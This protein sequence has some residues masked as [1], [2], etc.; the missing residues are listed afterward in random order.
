MRVWSKM[1]Y[2]KAE[3]NVMRDGAHKGAITPQEYLLEK[4]RDDFDRAKE[5]VNFIDKLRDKKNG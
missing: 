3:P 1:K 4:M 5:C 2:Y